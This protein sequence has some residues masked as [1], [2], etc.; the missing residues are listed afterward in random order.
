MVS[1]TSPAGV[2]GVKTSISRLETDWILGRLAAFRLGVPRLLPDDEPL[3]LC[4]ASQSHRTE[5]RKVAW[6]AY[7]ERHLSECFFNKIKHYRRILKDLA[8]RHGHVTLRISPH[9][10]AVMCQQNLG[11]VSGAHSVLWERKR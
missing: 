5:P 2:T 3:P 6:F 1:I 7:K 11:F 10:A 4:G 8:Q 9:P